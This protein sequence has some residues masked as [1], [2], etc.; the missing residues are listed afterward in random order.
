M[1]TY[2]SND[3]MDCSRSNNHWVV[4]I[5]DPQRHKTPELLAAM[6]RMLERTGNRYIAAEDSGTSVADL[7]VMA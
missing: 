6:G 5:G 3:K 2:F 4:I 1:I 7:S